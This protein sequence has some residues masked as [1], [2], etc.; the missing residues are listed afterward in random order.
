MNKLMNTDFIKIL[1]S[2]LVVASVLFLAGCSDDDDPK[3]EDTPEL[4]TKVTLTFTPTGE[5][6]PVVV[7]ATDPDGLGVQDLAP[8]G[9]INLVAGQSYALAITLINGLAKVTDPGYNI[10]E[11]VEEEGDEHIFF[12]AWTGNV[13]SDP[14]GDGN[15]DNREDVVNYNDEDENGLPV[16]LSTSW[17]AGEASSGEFRVIL[18]HQPDLKSAS[19]NS[20]D[21]ET[22]L[23]LEFDI[24]VE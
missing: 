5:G 24:A 10:T 13:F 19:S 23:D 6:T 4:I 22:D 16:G 12:F 20:S 9:P 18:K 3:K 2:V 15:I 7:T 8:D 14:A 11:E 21:G 17:I 1:S